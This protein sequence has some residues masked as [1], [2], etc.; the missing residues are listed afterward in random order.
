MR[1][2]GLGL[3]AGEWKYALPFLQGCLARGIPAVLLYLKIVLGLEIR[4]VQI[5]KLVPPTKKNL[6]VLQ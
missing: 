4:P 3:W 5:V 6:I 1:D 2:F